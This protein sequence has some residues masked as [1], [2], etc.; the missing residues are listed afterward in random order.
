MSFW[1]GNGGKPRQLA[2]IQ[3]VAHVEFRFEQ[4]ATKKTK[5]SGFVSFVCFCGSIPDFEPEI[6]P[7]TAIPLTDSG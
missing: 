6:I 3:W 4:K 2:G 1:A 5:G 7:L